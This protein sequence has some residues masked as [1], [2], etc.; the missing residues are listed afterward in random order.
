MSNLVLTVVAAWLLTAVGYVVF[1]PLGACLH[2]G[3]AALS[4]WAWLVA[5]RAPRSE[6]ALRPR[7]EAVCAEVGVVP[8]VLEAQVY[9][10][11]VSCGYCGTM[12]VGGR[13]ST[14]GAPRLG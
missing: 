10:A 7:A 3:A 8:L 13:C 11:P 12:S 4:V 5:C 2:V 6:P 14:C 9:P 1:V